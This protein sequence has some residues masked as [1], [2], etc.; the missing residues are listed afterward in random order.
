MSFEIFAPSITPYSNPATAVG[1]STPTGSYSNGTLFFN[2]IR[3]ILYVFSSGLWIEISSGITGSTGPQGF[4]SNTATGPTG[5]QGFSAN[6]GPT[7]PQGFSANTG[8]TGPIGDGVLVPS[9]YLSMYNSEITGSGYI[10][11]TANSFVNQGITIDGINP[12]IIHIN[13]PGVYKFYTAIYTTMVVA[14]AING[15]NVTNLINVTDNGSFYYSFTA[16]GYSTVLELDGSAFSF[17][18]PQRA[19]FASVEL[20]TPTAG[21]SYTGPTGPIGPQGVKTFVVQHPLHEN[22][23]LIHACL[24]GPE[25]GVYYRGDG[26]LSFGICKIYL[27]YYAKNLAYSWSVQLTPIDTPRLISSS[28]VKDGYF[29]VNGD[30]SDNGEFFWIVHGKRSEIEI[31]YSKEN[32]KISGDGP[33]TYITSIK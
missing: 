29:V 30:K 3:N 17:P 23:Y 11:W 14:L 12:S 25:A 27:P 7:G 8:P 31:E 15:V 32:T 26:K 20:V 6:T 16:V 1:G 21:Y 18:I 5:P 24:E 2:N 13:T 28:R 4:S 10:N 33:Y 9:Q 22:K 19:I